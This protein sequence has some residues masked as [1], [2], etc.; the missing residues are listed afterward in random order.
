[1]EDWANL[2]ENFGSDQSFNNAL[3]QHPSSY[4]NF[5]PLDQDYN[6]FPHSSWSTDQPLS[7]SNFSD[8]NFQDGSFSTGTGPYYTVTNPQPFSSSSFLGNGFQDGSFSPNI[9]PHYAATG[10]YSMVYPTQV[11]SFT[12]QPWST[13]GHNFSIMHSDCMAGQPHVD[14]SR[15]E[16]SLD[17]RGIMNVCSP[18]ELLKFGDTKRDI[19]PIITI[20]EDILSQSHVPTRDTQPHVSPR[21]TETT[22]EPAIYIRVDVQQLETTWG[23]IHLAE[24]YLL[25]VGK[26]IVVRLDA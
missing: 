25:E 12:Q 8:N 2:G 13:Q 10:P 9:E 15:I 16:M 21:R 14:C 20:T 4:G 5:Q 26:A 23:C 7:N 17:Y 3:P 11:L 1:M 24:E 6:G 18:K 22:P 19:K